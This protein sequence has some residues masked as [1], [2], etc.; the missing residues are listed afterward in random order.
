[1]VR[2]QGLPRRAGEN[3]SVRV[4][5]ELVL[6]EEAVAHRRPALRLGDMG[7]EPRFVAGFDVLDLEVAAIGDDVDPLDAEDRTGRFGGLFQQAHIDDL[8]D[9]DDRG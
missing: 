3:I 7:R 9:R 2:R 1:M 5:T 8:I 6:A 4:V